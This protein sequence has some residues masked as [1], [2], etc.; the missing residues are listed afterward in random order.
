MTTTFQVNS[1]SIEAVKFIEFARTLP[2]VKEKKTKKE[3][4]FEQIPGLAYTAEERIAS[5]LQGLEDYRAG[6]IVSNEDMGRW[7]N[8]LQ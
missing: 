6:R 4:P 8:D 1:D 3:E 5:V 7:I 2:F